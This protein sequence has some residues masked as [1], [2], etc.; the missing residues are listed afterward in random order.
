MRILVVSDTHGD[1]YALEQ[2]ALRE[3]GIDIYLHAGDVCAPKESIS[4][5]A[6]VRG[7]C[8]GYFRED[9][10]TSYECQ[11]PYGKLH[12]EHYPLR[13]I[14]EASL[15]TEGVKIFIH[16]HTH[17][18]EQRCDGGVYTFC[19]GSLSFPR[20]NGKGTY[21]ILDIDEKEVKATFKEL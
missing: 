1:N 21:L 8:D 3:H 9:Y 10:K 16:G 13:D 18:R 15:E 17:V 11:T 5:F 6:A 12:M 2:V 20:D 4:P 14:T 19:P 7:N